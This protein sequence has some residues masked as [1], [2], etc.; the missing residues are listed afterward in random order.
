M[1]ESADGVFYAVT[2]DE[3][4][5]PCELSNRET[6]IIQ[7]GL[8]WQKQKDGSFKMADKGTLVTNRELIQFQEGRVTQRITQA[9]ARVRILAY[10][11]SGG[12]HVV[13]TTDVYF[14]DEKGKVLAYKDPTSGKWKSMKFDGY[15]SVSLGSLEFT[16][17][18]Q[19]PTNGF[20]KHD[21]IT[22]TWAFVEYVD[23]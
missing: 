11:G 18:R 9:N 6:H 7:N 5:K 23:V 3:S 12:D 8:V 16:D 1:H 17:G 10:Y 22:N 21:E 14:S 2:F 20:F 13:F 19:V 15:H 4:G